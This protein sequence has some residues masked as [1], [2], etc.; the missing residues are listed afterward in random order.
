[1]SIRNLAAATLIAAAAIAGS[2]SPADAGV[3]RQVVRG[4]IHA[5]AGES[6]SRG[7]F[8]MMVADRSGGAHV[9]RL[10]AFARRLD[11]SADTEFHVVLVSSDGLSTADFGAM[12]VNRFGFGF[13]LFDSRREDLPA[14]AAT[15]T[16]FGGGT[17]EVRDGDTAVLSGDIPAFGGGEAGSNV[18]GHDRQR[19]ISTD[20]SFAGRG[21]IV[22][23]RQEIALDEREEVRVTCARMESGATYTVVVVAEDTTET[24]LGTFTT[25]DPLGLGGFRL[26]TAHGDTIGGGGVLG[27]AGQR[28]EV[29]DADSN[30]V[31]EGTFPSF[32]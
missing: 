31:L 3:Q 26:S 17:I 4:A 29:R 23:R 24:E 16:D 19:L 11:R 15:L 14:G 5:T 8:R 21:V 18:F 6:S 30:V 13:L 32:E 9:E 1:M 20:L 12:R 28:V 7:R 10:E 2:G 22:A 27:L 25:S